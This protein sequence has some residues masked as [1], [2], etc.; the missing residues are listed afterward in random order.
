MVGNCSISVVIPNLDMGGYLPDAV[1]SIL[2]Q[3]AE[4]DE[5][6]VVDAGSSDDSLEIISRLMGKFPQIRLLH[7]E[8]RNPSAV[9]NRALQVASGEIIAFLD[10]D[11][12]WPADKLTRQFERI[13]AEPRVEVVSG[14]VQYFDKLDPERLVPAEDSR[15]ETLFHVHLGAAIF[16]RSVFERVGMFDE[17][18]LYSE[19]VDLLLRVLEAD[20]PMTIIRA[21]TLYYRRH[22]SSLMAQTNPAKERDFKKVLAASIL[23]R[24]RQGKAGALP[25]FESLIEPDHRAGGG[26]DED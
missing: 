10:A 5:I 11:D 8:K 2:R 3:D 9:R 23:R 20:I 18:L 15:T 26:S 22:E 14:F 6:L 19:D 7:S 12:I 13:Q 1:A 16:H 25:P 17:N 21:R 4:V 24:R